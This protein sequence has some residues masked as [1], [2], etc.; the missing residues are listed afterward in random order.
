M[1]AAARATE[2]AVLKKTSEQMVEEA[3]RRIT[4]VTPDEVAEVVASGQVLVVDVREREEWDQGH[5]PQAIHVPRG[6]LE[7]RADPASPL[8]DPRLHPGR[9]ILVHCA[10]GKRSALA[11]ATLQEMGYEG[12]LN[13]E[14]GFEAWKEAG[15]PVSRG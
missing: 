10:L 12:V 2:V 11:T 14:G 5:I 7:F 4:S 3:R 6:E 13:L 9:R 15:Y 8:A 1:G